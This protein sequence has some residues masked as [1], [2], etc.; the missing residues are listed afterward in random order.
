[1]SST[2]YFAGGCFWCIEAVFQR[3]KG[4][5]KVLSG[6]TGGYIKNPAYRE[7]CTGRTGHAEAVAVTFNPKQIRLVD[8]L[9]VFFNVHDPTTLNRQGNDQGTQYRSA[10]FYQDAKQKE[11]IEIVMRQIEAEK[12]YPEPLVTQ[13]KPFSVFYEAEALHHN[14]YNTHQEEPY[15]ALTITPKLEKL[16]LYFKNYL[17]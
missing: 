7:V 9:L 16:K 12:I 13:V 3:L 5:E 11:T 14:Y 15:C 6:Y 2:I 4:V 10:I 1:M 17:E 8:L